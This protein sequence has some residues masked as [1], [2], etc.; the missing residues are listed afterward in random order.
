MVVGGG[1]CNAARPGLSVAV[2]GWARLLRALCCLLGG[3][4]T[5]A[6]GG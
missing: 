4:C 5:G 1:V 3:G 2:A 6:V